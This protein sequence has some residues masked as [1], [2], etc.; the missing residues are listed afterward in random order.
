L[1]RIRISGPARRDIENALRHSQTDFGAVG[2]ARYARLIDA[3]I[4]DLARD[5]VRVGV[6]PIEEVRPGYFAYHLRGSARSSGEVGRPRHLVVFRLGTGG[7]VIVV[8]LLHERQFLE[9]HL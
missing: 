9:R 3:A 8:R 1:S 5:P 6:R 2:R 7:I 4:R